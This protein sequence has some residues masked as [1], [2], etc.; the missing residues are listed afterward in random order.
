MTASRTVLVVDDDPDIVDVIGMILENQGYEVLKASNGAEALRRLRGSPKPGLVLLD[1]MMPVM[2][3][4]EFRA[5]QMLEP[6][7]AAVPVIA[8]SGDGSVAEKAASLGA[9]GHL[10]KPLDFDTLVRAVGRHF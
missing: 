5:E 9:S 3:G 1:L 7:L 10:K 2:S 6:A 4:W 8:L